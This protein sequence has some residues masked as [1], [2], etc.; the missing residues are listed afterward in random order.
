MT[1]APHRPTIAAIA[2][3][4][5]AAGAI[6]HEGVGHGGACLLSDGGLVGMSSVHFQCGA[7]GI[8]VAA[9]GTMANVAAGLALLMALRRSS[10]ARPHL[11]YALWLGMSVNL[12]QAAGYF[13]FSGALGIGDWAAIVRM[14]GG[15]AMSR[16]AL[17]AAG[18]VL[19]LG[20][21]RRSEGR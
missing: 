3:V 6:L 19:Y 12:M 5:Y 17:A 16:A 8:A 2:V 21:V 9:G 18:A 14:T 15:G 11:R 4:I 1:D 10:A 13:L 7:E 20:V